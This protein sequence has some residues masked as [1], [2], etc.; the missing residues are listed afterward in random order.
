MTIRSFTGSIQNQVP[1][2]PP[3]KKLGGLTGTGSCRILDN[4]K[5]QAKTKTAGKL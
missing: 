3:Q 2:A 1:N 5:I 4:G